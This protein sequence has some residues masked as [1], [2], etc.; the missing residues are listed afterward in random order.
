M[1]NM[2]TLNIVNKYIIDTQHLGFSIGKQTRPRP[3]MIV[4]YKKIRIL[5]CKKETMST[6]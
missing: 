1:L 6:T 3:H 5:Q 4:V 2:I